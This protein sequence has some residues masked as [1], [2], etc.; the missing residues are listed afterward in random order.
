MGKQS[1]NTVLAET[2]KACGIDH[3]FNVPMIVPPGVKAMT[4]NG[5][6]SIAT[7]S[8]KAAAYMADGYARESGRMGVCASQAI[9]AINLAAGLLDAYMAKAPILAI[10]GG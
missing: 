3:F 6:R 8:E 1:G 9:G 5:V 10:T 2:L 4:A 7:H